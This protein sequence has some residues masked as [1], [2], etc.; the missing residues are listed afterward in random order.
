MI[1]S[2]FLF[3]YFSFAVLLRMVPLRAQP[4]VKVGGTCPP[5]PM[6]SAPMGKSC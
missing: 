2:I 4:F 1:E 6:V 5:C 3:C